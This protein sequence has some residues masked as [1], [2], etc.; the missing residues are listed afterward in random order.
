MTT[1][2][3][4]LQG[5]DTGAAGRLYMAL[6]LSDKKWLLVLGD[7]QR[8][9]SSYTV[10]AGDVAGVLTAMGKAKKRCGL[11]GEVRVHSCYEA[12]RDGFWLHRWLVEQ[13]IDNVVVDAASIEVNRR[14]R[15]TK[16]DRMDG[17]K[18]LSMLLRYHGG[19]A[20]VWA[21]LRVPTV[22]QEDAR[23]QLREIARLQQEAGAHRNR[24]GSLLV[25]HNLRVKGIGQRGWS[26]WWQAHA[27]Q[28]PPELRAE[29]EREVSRLELVNTQFKALRQAQRAALKVKSEATEAGAAAPAHPLVRRL[30][31]LRAIGANSAWWLDKEWLGWRRFGNRREV[32]AS[33]G[34]APSPYASGDSRHEQGIAK[35][36]NK[37]I[38]RLLIELAWTWLRYQPDSELTHWFNARFARGGSRT[39]RIGIVAL[40]RRL[41][42]A[43]WRYADQ[44]VLP[45][46][47]RLKSVA[48]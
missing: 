41:A 2:G 24:I 3:T 36:G 45:K 9:P 34:L 48:A 28:L 39:R 6:E 19:E 10:N 8:A 20:R 4:A 15:R 12:G 18:L 22:E 38:R 27:E 13:G 40:A 5:K 44:G 30:A 21:V 26:R 1:A 37:R 17:A 16:T 31:A 32:G 25:L 7:G 29:I 42:I 47:A 23:R 46:G 35:A 11:V 43:L 14:A 33:V